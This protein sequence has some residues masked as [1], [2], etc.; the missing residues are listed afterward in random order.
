METHYIS[1]IIERNGDKKAVRDV[2]CSD[3]SFGE[4][5]NRTILSFFSF[6]GS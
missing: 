1:H 4:Q 5:N 2:Q 6:L 3:G